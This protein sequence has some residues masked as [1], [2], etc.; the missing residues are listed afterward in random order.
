VFPSTGF[1]EESI[2]GIIA[3]ANGLI[4]WHLAIRLDAVLQAEKLPARVTNLRTCLPDMNQD[5]LTHFEG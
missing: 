2:E 3:S 1:G 4:A 5:S